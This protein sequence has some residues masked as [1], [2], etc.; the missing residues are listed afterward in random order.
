MG[1]R[2]S[3]TR[4]TS[5]RHVRVCPIVLELAIVA[6]VFGLYRAGRT[7]SRDAADRALRNAAD[8]VHLER[9][10]G[11]FHE[12]SVQAWA[13]RSQTLVEFLN[14]YYV[15]VHFPVTIAFLVWAYL[16][17]I[18]AYRLVR[19]WFV[20]VTLAALALHVAFPLAPPRMTA[21][22]V[23][24]LRVFGPRIYTADPQRSV[25]NQF[26]AMPSL[27][28]GWALMLGV[29]VVAIKRTN[30]SLLALAHPMVTLVAIVAT[31]NHYWLDAIVVALLAVAA[32]WM[33][34]MA[35]A[36]AVEM[37]P[38]AVSTAALAPALSPAR[39]HALTSALT[40]AVTQEAA[41]I[42]PP[43]SAPI[44]PP[45]GPPAWLLPTP[46]PAASAHQARGRCHRHHPPAANTAPD[47]RD[48][49]HAGDRVHPMGRAPSRHA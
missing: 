28:F 35:H 25:A 11:I 38:H 5:A 37:L 10:L 41:L 48:L 24:T 47:E 29:S 18:E 8:V 34:L 22:F 33:V 16:R 26:A 19:T 2:G 4:S 15:S 36:R 43:A 44:R 45:A 7:I 3:T 12:Q 32:G 17:H 31:G 20:G 40:P 42:P 46:R 39:P 21:G 27:H 14:R 6:S 13:M 23:D 9:S 49:A 1:T 30:L